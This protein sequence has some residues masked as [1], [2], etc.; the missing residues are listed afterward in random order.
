M[1]PILQ[2]LPLKSSGLRVHLQQFQTVVL[3]AVVE[4][5][6]AIDVVDLVTPHDDILAILRIKIQII[7]E[8]AAVV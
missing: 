2:L 4:F 1:F 8:A 6:T 5:I 3:C 7:V